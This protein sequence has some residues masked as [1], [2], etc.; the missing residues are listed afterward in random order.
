MCDAALQ[1][2]DV[3][4]LLEAGTH[5]VLRAH[6]ALTQVLHDILAPQQYEQLVRMHDS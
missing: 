4:G 5:E 2:L 6:L 3:V 1:L